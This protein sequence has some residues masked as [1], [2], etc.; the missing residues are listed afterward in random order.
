LAKLLAFSIIRV[1]PPPY[2]TFYAGGIAENESGEKMPV[3]IEAEYFSHLKIGLTG[4]VVKNK[5]DFGE[6]NYFVPTI[7]QETRR[8]VA[9]LTGATRGIG[10]ATALELARR[11]FDIAITD[12][13]LPDEG[14]QLLEEIERLGMK[15]KFFRSDV[16][17]FEEVERVVSQIRGELGRIDVLV[18]NAGIN[19]DKLLIDMTPES[20]QKVID[21]DLT[22]VFN[23]TKA[24]LPL[25]MAQGGGRI[26]NLSSMSALDG[27]IGQAN[28][29]AA[30]GGIISFTK[31]VARENAQYNIL[32]NAIAPGC[33]RTRMTDQL[34]SGVLKERV[35]NIPLGRRGE[36][37]EVAKL[38]AFLAIDC[39][40]ITG[41]LISINAGEYV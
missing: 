11:G 32:C 39:G 9:L 23:C 2:K 1:V 27:A 40:Y 41:Q 6:L 14:K 3:R 35:S 31:N 19:L 7:P 24:V 29:A 28:Y 8:K 5:T 21:V 18:N 16:S 4:N 12:V 10:K 25:M 33:I 26:V 34:P 30:K 22:G 17:R 37:E 15:A 38:I 36:P 13:E 20:W